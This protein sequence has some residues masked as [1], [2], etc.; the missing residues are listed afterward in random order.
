VH[1]DLDDAVSIRA[2]KRFVADRFG[3]ESPEIAKGPIHFI[4]KLLGKRI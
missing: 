1:T 3:T 2:L 4:K